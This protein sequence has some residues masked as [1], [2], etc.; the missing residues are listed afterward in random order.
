MFAQSFVRR[1]ARLAVAAA[2]VV[3]SVG[4][5]TAATAAA[6]PDHPETPAVASGR[7]RITEEAWSAGRAAHGRDVT[8]TEALE[9]YWSPERMRDAKPAD[10]APTYK[11][12]I[13]RQAKQTAEQ[14]EKGK[15]QKGGPK[16]G[17]ELSIEPSFGTDSA[18][19]PAAYTPT[20]SS[21]HAVART[22]GKV[23]F[24]MAG[25]NWVCSG[26]VINTEG[27]D[28]VWTAGHCVHGGQ[29]GSWAYNWTFVPGYDDDLWNPRP[30]GT[31]SAINLHSMTGWT[32]SSDWNQDMGVAYMNTLNGWHI[33]DRVGGQ[34]LRVNYGKSQWINA[35]GYTSVAPYDGGNLN[36]CWGQSSPEWDYGFTSAESLKISCDMNRGASGGA[37]LQ[38]FDGN[39]GYLYGVNSRVD[40]YTA[41]TVVKSPYFDNTAWDLFNATRYL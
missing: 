21:T 15:A 14:Q 18:G 5:T 39:W 2:I 32:N 16:S 11:A 36:Q 31:W 23:F 34:G 12:A 17:P 25:G 7:Q 33:A 24:S 20:Y 26:T 13:A 8:E 28:Q 10:E 40:S 35:F 22:S 19:G 27:R 38:S 41:P 1:S 6:P 3:G 29:G 4:A 9:A 37:W 30:Y